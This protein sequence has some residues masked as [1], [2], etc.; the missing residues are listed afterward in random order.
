MLINR[1][2]DASKVDADAELTPR[3]ELAE[4]DGAH[5]AVLRGNWTTRRVAAIDSTIRK[6]EKNKEIKSLRI[7]LSGVGRI[8]TAGAWLVERLL[9]AMRARGVEP[10]VA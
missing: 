9:S 1:R 8:D 3:I 6:I 2:K 4:R 5:H 10:V 7:D